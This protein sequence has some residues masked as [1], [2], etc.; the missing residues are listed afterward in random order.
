MERIADMFTFN[1]QPVL[2]VVDD[3][4]GG[5]DRFDHTPTP[6]TASQHRVRR[7]LAAA[8]FALASALAA[9]EQREG[10]SASR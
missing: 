3:Q 7:A 5:H 2:L 6:D 10:I 1:G 9:P 4:K 8:L